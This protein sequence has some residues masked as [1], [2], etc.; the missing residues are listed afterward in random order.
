[1]KLIVLVLQKLISLY[2]QTTLKQEKGLINS[3][4]ADIL[5]M[6]SPGDGVK[7]LSTFK[8]NSQKLLSI[9]ALEA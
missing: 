4:A 6:R 8:K 9:K 5:A 2:V 1:M 3:Q 7:T